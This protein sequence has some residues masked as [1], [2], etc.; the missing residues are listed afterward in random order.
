MMRKY[1]SLR[2]RGGGLAFLLVLLL[3]SRNLQAQGLPKD[4]AS[5]KDSAPDPWVLGLS[6]FVQVS[7]A[8]I[9]SLDGRAFTLEEAAAIVAHSGEGILDET[10]PSLLASTLEPLPKRGTED[11]DGRPLLIQTHLSK[12]GNDIPYYAVEEGV[13][14]FNGL[15]GLVAGFYSLEDEEIECRIL[16]FAKGEAGFPLEDPPAF[17]LA[18]SGAIPE[19]DSLAGKLLPGIH[20]WVAGRELA[21]VD[22]RTEPE[23]GIV[24]TVVG[25][26]PQTS[27]SLDG[28][29]VFLYDQGSYEILM[30]RKGF[31]EARRT[32]ASSPGS[33][34]SLLVKMTPV[35]SDPSEVSGESI[36]S[37]SET[38]SWGEKSRFLE[39]ERKF[40]AALGRIV[41]S[42]PVSALAIGGYFSCSE[43]YSRSAV[44]RS[45]LSFSGAG[46]LLSVSL[47]AAFIVDSALKLM[48]VLHASR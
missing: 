14:A 34:S 37:A 26:P 19:L 36:F 28:S 48:D 1:K 39:S 44:S 10:I 42:I 46:A 38:L 31:E 29:R 25:D 27:I 35:S 12:S 6:K 33:Y 22:I 47:S 20:A 8:T 40:S 9:A 3:T 7:P 16:L 5:Q 18:F 2:Q 23:Q 30:N 13:E 21:V 24:F 11:K 41:I 32:L 4:S 17:S 45:A 43:A 15:D